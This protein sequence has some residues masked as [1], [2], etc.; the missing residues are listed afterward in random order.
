M[1][2]ENSVFKEKQQQEQE[3]GRYDCQFG[4]FQDTICTFCLASSVL[5]GEALVT[6]YTNS[7]EKCSFQYQKGY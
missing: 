2:Q 7:G 6:M 4:F 1:I 5:F 3:M